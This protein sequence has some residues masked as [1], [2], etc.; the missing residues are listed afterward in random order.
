VV[1]A[2]LAAGL[3]ATAL[4][5]AKVTVA[6]PVT[7]VAAT[8][9][10]AGAGEVR[11]KP[12]SAQAEAPSTGARS[13]EA[14]AGEVVF[15]Y[16]SNAFADDCGPGTHC[17]PPEH[18]LPAGSRVATCVQPK[19]GDPG[20]GCDAFGVQ[21][22]L[23]QPALLRQA[24]LSQ[25][26]PVRAV[27]PGARGNVGFADIDAVVDRPPFDHLSLTVKNLRP[28]SGGKDAEQ[29]VVAQADVDRVTA[30]RRA[31]LEAE[32]RRSLAAEAGRRGLR[33]ADAAVDVT[34]QADPAV[35]VAGPRT[36][37]TVT[38]VA[39]GTGYR[40]DALKAAA[41]QAVRAALAAGRFLV[42]DSVVLDQPHA[43]ADGGVAVAVRA[44]ASPV[45]PDQVRRTAAGHQPGTAR[46]RL[47]RRYGD[48]TVRITGRPPVVPWLPVRRAHITVAVRPA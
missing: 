3:W 10:V 45:D 1:A 36:K 6:A 16:R 38:A 29:G 19:A 37:V 44:K 46:A 2:L 43:A 9:T 28:T 22:V 8:A 14:A 13:A 5:G 21:F 11:G 7:P 39:H 41:D 20:L 23:T 48:G 27:E 32:A 15:D 35:G 40:A 34:A 31:G 47:E 4:A 12:A 30:A 25:P 42:P 26:V 17:P 33:T 24:G 18:T